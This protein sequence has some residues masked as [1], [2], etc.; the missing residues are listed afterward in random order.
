MNTAGIEHLFQ[1]TRLISDNADQLKK[2][3]GETFNVFSILKMES[4]ENDTH[5]NFLGNL[6][7]PSGTHLLGSLFL[8]HF[9]ECTELKNHLDASSTRVYL[10]YAC[11][12]IDNE[13]RTGGRIDLF[14]VDRNENSISIENKIYASDQY[15]QIE[16][17]VNFNS[18]RNKVLYLT[19]DGTDA[20]DMSRGE[21]QAGT[22]YSL[23]SYKETIVT[24]L[25]LC[26]K[27]AAS[28][29][30][31]RE[32]IK[33]YQILLK[34]LTNT[35]DEKNM[36]ELQQLILKNYRSAELIARNFD[37]A[38]EKLC[39][40]LRTAVIDELNQRLRETT[41]YAEEGSKI[42][43]SYAQIWIRNKY[44]ENAPVYFGM[45][46]F[47]TNPNY[48]IFHGIFT[49]G[50]V[51]FEQKAEV[52]RH[53]QYWSNLEYV[54]DF[55]GVTLHLGNVE[56]IEKLFSFSHFFDGVVDHLCSSFMRYLE[57]NGQLVE[58]YL[59]QLL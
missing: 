18:S 17:Y 36:D 5:S 50:D 42:T 13:T 51:N 32:T 21:L 14:L 16:R 4:K 7:D 47:G 41:Y 12:K 54:S 35:M 2:A 45:E 58:D 46:P 1:S 19:L 28:E 48:A 57:E 27:E 11:G 8:E 29:P 59:S 9:L 43:A 24:W 26:I 3:K 15:Q 22:D 25:G 49:Y 33:Q 23:I 37:Q 10:E 44:K 6:L 31:V 53:N 34:Q 55:E 20:S 40:Q 39:T 56:F 38:K 52:I 30:I